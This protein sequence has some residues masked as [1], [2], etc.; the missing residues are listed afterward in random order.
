MI[1]K[2]AMGMG[3]LLIGMSACLISCGNSSP[4]SNNPTATPTTAT[5]TPT[6]TPHVTVIA[7]FGG[8][9]AE[10]VVDSQNNIYA[11]L[12]GTVS[13]GKITSAGVTSSINTITSPW[14]LS[15]DA[16][17]DVF[18]S[19]EGAA[20]V[21]EFPYA[22]GQNQLSIANTYAVLVNSAG[23]T[24]Y[25]AH[26]V[27]ASAAISIAGAT[28]SS[29][30]IGGGTILG[31]ALDSH[32]NLFF[33]DSIARNEIEEITAA[34]LSSGSPIATLVAG[35]ALAY[36]FVDGAGASAEFNDPTGIAVDS[37]DNIYVADESNLAIREITGGPGNWTVSTVISASGISGISPALVL[38]LGD[39]VGVAVDSNGIL[40]FD[41]AS[42]GNIY[43]Y[44]P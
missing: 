16:A 21:T 42:S 9:P 13:I 4:T 28:S 38:A 23:T 14:S 36:G 31:L 11:A 39:P 20:G 6:P 1:L 27:N 10:M 33:A 29:I 25:V 22:G 44:Q 41:D 18:F 19:G 5:S 40:Y 32:G 2:R 8:A 43:R 34:S 7:N 35:S 17:G 30:A 37:N 3:L 24:L 12:S 26:G 15:L